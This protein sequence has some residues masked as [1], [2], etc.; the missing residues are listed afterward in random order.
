LETDNCGNDAVKN[1]ADTLPR[2]IRIV[3]QG[4]ADGWHLGVQVYVSVAGKTV[5]DFAVGEA[6]PG[7]PMTASTIMWWLSCSK[8]IMAVAIAQLWESGELELDDAVCRHISEFRTKGKEAVTLQ[9]LLTHT[10]SMNADVPWNLTDWDVIVS[11]LCES[12]LTAG[13]VPG[14]DA[15]YN[16]AGNWYLL[17]EVV[18][19]LDGRTYDRYAR[20]AIFEP[21]GMGDS[22]IGMPTERYYAYGNRVGLMY[23]TADSE[24]KSD[25]PQQRC[26][27]CRPGGSGHG[28]IRELGRFYEMLL[29]RGSLAGV[30]VISP[31]AVETLTSRHRAGMFDRTFQH[32]MDWGLG[33]I[34]D[35]NQYGVDTVPY[36]YGRHCSQKTFGHSG[37]Q[38]SCAFADPER[39]LVVAWVSNGTPGEERHGQR[40]RAINTAIYE[41]LSLV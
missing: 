33:F 8:P 28:P 37:C 26:L 7:V 30:S 11:R 29:G 17:G 32:T 25:D 6:R 14:R 3:E 36:G 9:Q 15:G 5:A 20:E 24:P 34:I 18:R 2:T 35:S 12:E 21:L 4:F 41:D 40:Q 1:P 16:V 38:S 31:Q 23:D 27:T 22:W 10:V 19:R 39:G 13:W